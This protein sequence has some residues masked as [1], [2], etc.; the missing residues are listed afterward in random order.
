MSYS[1][2]CLN[3]VKMHSGPAFWEAYWDQDVLHHRKRV[4]IRM[5]TF[6]IG[7]SVMILTLTRFDGEVCAVQVRSGL[8]RFRHSSLMAADSVVRLNWKVRRLFCHFTPALT[9]GAYAPLCRPHSTGT[10][11]KCNAKLAKPAHEVAQEIASTANATDHQCYYHDITMAFDLKLH[12]T[13]PMIQYKRRH[14]CTC[15]GTLDSVREN[16]GNARMTTP[17]QPRSHKSKGDLIPIMTM[18]P[19]S[20]EQKDEHSQTRSVA[21]RLKERESAWP[22]NGEFG[23]LC[24]EAQRNMSRILTRATQTATVPVIRTDRRDNI[25]QQL[26]HRRLDD[27]G[28]DSLV[29]FNH[30]WSQQRIPDVEEKCCA[31][32]SIPPLHCIGFLR[33]TRIATACTPYQGGLHHSR[34]ASGNSRA[35][36]KP[37]VKVSGVDAGEDAYSKRDDGSELPVGIL[38]DSDGLHWSLS[39]V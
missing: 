12:C 10:K 31:A 38:E 2:D 34:S 7:Q 14:S 22:R 27:D 16:V 33:A 29:M 32:C 26:V 3:G 5:K 30:G 1:D 37:W 6:E 18:K 19:G 15:G 11:L 20:S 36:L 4:A 13:L 35:S 39:C 25:A 28:G 17:S 23:W 9:C 8:R 24:R 21:D